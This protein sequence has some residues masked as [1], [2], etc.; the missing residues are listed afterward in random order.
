MLYFS[1]AKINIG[2]NVV[3]KR[4]DGYHN[5]ESVFYPIPLQDALEFVPAKKT[6]ITNSGISID[7]DDDDNLILR[8]FRCLQKDF[9]LP[10]LA[11]HIFK[12]IPFGAGLGGGSSN[13]AATLLALNEYF[14]LKISTE[15]L[16][17]YA[18]KIGSDCAFFIENKPALATGK[19]DILSLCK[20]ELSDYFLLLIRP[21]FGV[22]TPLAYSKLKPRKPDHALNELIQNDI[23][24]WKTTVKNDFENAVFEMHP[25]LASIKNSMYEKGAV[26]AAMSGSGS[27]IYG[28]F[29]DE[30]KNTDF[31]QYWSWGNYLKFE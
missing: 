20:I 31:P 5:L 30:V 12:K 23:V 3:A 13:A 19:G 10:E 29:K 2:L 27:A 22:S 24:N 17:E 11:F 4:T 16:I 1:N 21:D 9:Q 28:L 18:T 14:E 7:C 8:A 15:K 6:Q 25:V 26:Y